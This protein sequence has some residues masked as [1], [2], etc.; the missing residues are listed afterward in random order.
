MKFTESMLRDLVETAMS[1]EEV[2]DL[3]TMTGF[4]LEEV[5]LVEGEKVLDINVMA[6]RGDGASV[7]GLA[8]E[9][10]AKDPKSRPTPLYQALSTHGPQEGAADPEATASVRIESPLCTRFSIRVFEGL[11]NGPS[12]DWVQERLRKIGQRPISLLVDLTNTVMYETGQ[13][14]H[15]YDLDL[16]PKGSLVVREARAG[17]TLTTLDGTAH[18]L[19]AGMLM[20]CDETRPIGVAGVMGGLDTEVSETTTRCLLESAHF[21]HQAVRRTRKGLGLQTD[22]SYRFERYVDPEGTVRALDRFAE[23][24]EQCAGYKPLPLLIDVYPAPP[25]RP[26][27]VVRGDRTR[28]LLGLDVSSQQIAKYL[29]DLGSRVEQNGDDFSVAPP[30]WRIDLV[31]EDD[32]VEEVGRVHGYEK[33]PSLLPIGST[34]VGGVHGRSKFLDA[35]RGWAVR[36]GFTQCISHSLCAGSPLDAPGGHVHVRNPHSPELELL[37]NSCLPSVA[38]AALRN[39]G[40]GLKLFEVGRVFRPGSEGHH[41]ALISTSAAASGPTVTDAGFFAMKGTIETILEGTGF[42][43]SFSLPAVPDDRFHPTRQ[44]SWEGAV[45][46]GQIHPLVAETLGLPTETCLAEIDVTALWRLVPADDP[47][48]PFHRHPS[49]RRDMAVVVA[50]SVKYQDV[51]LVIEEACGDVLERHWLFDVYEGAGIDPGHHSLGIALLLRKAGTFTDEEANRVRD[52]AVSGLERL[53]AKLR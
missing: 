31:R 15:A 21:D 27:V 40:K 52:A 53:G 50:K 26:A 9:V 12:P 22:A 45:L 10:L 44:A 46:F 32:F 11:A 8:R 28:R 35:L 36:C 6:N 20:I 42:R 43:P 41:M 19:K 4:E 18:E 2:G 13:P 33:I 7:L 24:L 38:D 30:S 37:R 47:F 49:V 51:A 48:K 17:E 16:V 14:L 23:L 34:P 1:A 5:L 3:L 39:G 29:Q 25:V